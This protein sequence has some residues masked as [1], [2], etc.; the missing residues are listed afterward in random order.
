MVAYSNS[1]GQCF[2]NADLTFIN[3]LK[4]FA[5]EGR[6]DDLLKHRED[7]IKVYKDRNKVEARKMNR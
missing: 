2:I 1:F 4:K 7:L 3:E 5:A 6:A